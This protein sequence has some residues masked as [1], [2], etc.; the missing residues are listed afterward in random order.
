MCRFSKIAKSAKSPHPCVHDT[1]V[2]ILG[3]ENQHF[4]LQIFSFMIDVFR[5]QFCMNV[6]TVQCSIYEIYGPLCSLIHDC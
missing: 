3:L 6:F 5:R 4:K 2:I 1:T